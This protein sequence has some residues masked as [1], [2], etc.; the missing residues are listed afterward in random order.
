M[1]S[2]SAPGKGR[3]RDGLEKRA[4]LVGLCVRPAG[5]KGERQYRLVGG[6]QMVVGEPG[7]VRRR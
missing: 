2:E 6:A 5:R 1:K 3:R 4:G 7:G